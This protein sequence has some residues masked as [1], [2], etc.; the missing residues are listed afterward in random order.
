MF[1]FV[2]SPGKKKVSL[3]WPTSIAV[4]PL[5][6][7]LIFVDEESVL[8]LSQDAQI[9][10]VL[11]NVFKCQ[12]QHDAS[13]GRR[14]PGPVTAVTVDSRG[15]L[16]V[17]GKSATGDT[18]L[19]E[20][21]TAGATRNLLSQESAAC[22]CDDVP[23]KN[24]TCS[25]STRCA[26]R[27][28]ERRSQRKPLSIQLNHI[29][30]PLTNPEIFGFLTPRRGNLHVLVADESGD[31][32][33]PY[34]PTRE[35]YV[36]NR[37]GLHI[38][39]KDIITGKIQY[40]FL[41]SVNTSFGKLNKVTDASGN[42]VSFIRDYRN[43]VTTIELTDG[44]KY[45][46]QVS[47]RGLLERLSCP[48]NR[49]YRFEYKADHDS[50]LLV[51][52]TVAEAGSTSHVYDYDESGKLVGVTTPTGRRLELAAFIQPG[53]KPY[54]V[55]NIDGDEF[56]IRIERNASRGVFDDASKTYGTSLGFILLNPI[57]KSLLF[58]FFFGHRRLVTPPC[59]AGGD[60]S[61][62]SRCFLSGRRMD[63][64]LEGGVLCDVKS[65]VSRYANGSFVLQ[66]STDV[67]LRGRAAA[68][69]P[70]LKSSQSVEAQVF[71]L[72]QN[73]TVTFGTVDN[74]VSSVWNI[75]VEQS[76]EPW[77]IRRL[78]K[79][80]GSTTLTT[81]YDRSRLMETLYDPADEVVF[82]VQY[83]GSGRP[84][85]WIPRGQKPVGKDWEA[86]SSRQGAGLPLLLHHDSLGRLVGWRWITIGRRLSRDSRGRIVEVVGS[87]G[88]AVRYD[89]KDSKEAWGF[90]PVAVTTPSGRKY[91][92][93]YDARGGLDAIYTPNRGKH[94]F[95]LEP[96]I[97]TFKF[98]YFPPGSDDPYLTYLDEEG[99][100]HLTALPGNGGKVLYEYGKAQRLQ[101]V[102]YGGGSVSY[103]YVDGIVDGIEQASRHFTSQITFRSLGALP[104]E[105]KTDF[106]SRSGLADSKFQ[107]SWGSDLR[108]RRIDGRIGG[109]RLR[110]IRIEYD[111]QTGQVKKFGPFMRTRS[112]W[113][114]GAVTDGVATFVKTFDAYHRVSS[115]ALTIGGVLVF[116]ED[117]AYDSV[118]RVESSRV[119]SRSLGGAEATFTQTLNFTYDADGQL[120]Q[121]ESQE[122]WK[123][124]YDANGNL[125]SLQLKQTD[126]AMQTRDDR[127]TKFGQGTY[128]YDERGFVVQNAAE[129]QF[130]YDGR[131]LLMSAQRPDR[132]FVEYEYDHLHRLV[133]R[134]DHL[135]N[136]TQLFYASPQ[137]PRLVTHVFHPKE[138]RLTSLFYDESDNVVLVE[139]EEE[140]F[141]VA[142]DACGTPVKVFDARGAVLREMIRGPYGK[143]MW[144]SNQRLQIPVDFC[145]GILEPLTEI[146]HMS[147][148]RVYDPVIGQWM[149][150]DWQAVT[151]RVAR[152]HLLHL[153]RFNG[154]DPINYR[155]QMGKPED[156][157]GWMERLGYSPQSLNPQLFF[158]DSLLTSSIPSSSSFYEFFNLYFPTSA[159]VRSR[160]F[161]ASATN[162]RVA[163]RSGLLFRAREFS[164]DAASVASSTPESAIGSAFQAPEDW[165]PRVSS[166][167]GPLGAGVVMSRTPG[168]ALVRAANAAGAQLAAVFAGVLNNSEL[169]DLH[170]PAPTTH[171]ERFFFAKPDAGSLSED[172]AA[173]RS[174]AGKAVNVTTSPGGGKVY[175]VVIETE[176][177]E[178]HI[179]YG[180]TGD[181]LRHKLLRQLRKDTGD[182]AWRRE[183]DAAERGLRGATAWAP[184]DLT[185]L[186]DVGFASD[187][188][189]AYFHDAATYPLLAD[190]VI[191]ASFQ[192]RRRRGGK[193]ARR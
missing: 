184:S 182:A 129:A 144:D 86:S 158:A 39:T 30:Q 6:N 24:V 69:H 78:L 142:T 92:Y 7:S 94:K 191:N 169:L 82:S 57:P 160:S 28:F 174:R 43:E 103:R 110:D 100:V 49:E 99:R 156:R 26:V 36:F 155:R 79:I 51:S 167:D 124:T 181:K 53:E 104:K 42:K 35:L 128:R 33:I 186:R 125:M 168:R 117:F 153:Y 70:V 50:G 176:S 68:D 143:I 193:S 154:N 1:S 132:F 20:L 188:E 122:P 136:V 74:E 41:Y 85:E 3:R 189:F 25:H 67:S 5:D 13:V 60:L 161:L 90:Q 63:S 11:G 62:L 105:I 141:Y 185:E 55:C 81:E 118:G 10:T 114:V 47:R 84:T 48:E 190:D 14:S 40:T 159:S 76:E 66:H 140:K 21:D 172:Q 131:G 152:P 29:F 46:V 173:L 130:S 45:Q 183:K 162:A 127:L 54:V 52:K 102:L 4:N 113:N 179:R 109:K 111:R 8:Q 116:R 192:R 16:Y 37:Y 75:D 139:M 34:A 170:L 106:N 107:Y 146:V 150:P 2:L 12:G 108:L 133:L 27:R 163:P 19:L 178:L 101:N 115:S 138:N 177:T 44:H 151:T 83:N 147:E 120:T 123:F 22:S 121:V 157:F 137:K 134:R 71:P 126:I 135:G 23:K 119:E 112:E 98:S 17:A 87:D 93:S 72:P 59:P 148:G 73:Q 171:K 88:Q 180:D 149:T 56:T 89:Y 31:F 32:W 166:S 77:R 91:T 165:S 96:T 164:L 65:W 175:D 64:D 15:N 145:G 58:F 80:N 18:F 97:G 9:T 187:F 61:F 38:A 95:L